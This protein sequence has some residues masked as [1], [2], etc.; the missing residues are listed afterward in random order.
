[1]RTERMTQPSLYSDSQPSRR[2]RRDAV[3]ATNGLG[4]LAVTRE[5]VETRTDEPISGAVRRLR[6]LVE[7]LLEQTP[8]DALCDA[9]LAFAAE[10]ALIDMR[11]ATGEL[12]RLR[13]GIE[14]GSG[15]CQSCRRDTMV[16]VF[17]TEAVV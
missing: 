9:C 3:V 1:M 11:L 6:L 5:P 12:P 13:P 16:T 14:R 8:G 17:R 4:A 10:A 15:R 7:R 2:R